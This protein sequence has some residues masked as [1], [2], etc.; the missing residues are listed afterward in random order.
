MAPD[1]ETTLQQNY[2]TLYNTTQ[3]EALDWLQT[4]EKEGR[5]GKDVWAGA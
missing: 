5:Y 3:Q 4:L 1:V 2:Q